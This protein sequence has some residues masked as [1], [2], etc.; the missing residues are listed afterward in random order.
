[1]QSNEIESHFKTNEI[2]SDTSYACLGNRE[3]NCDGFCA[4]NCVLGIVMRNP[5]GQEHTIGV[6]YCLV[7]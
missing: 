3:D 5:D 1:V 4:P 6:V 2:K 7:S